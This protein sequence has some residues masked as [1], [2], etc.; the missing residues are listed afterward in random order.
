MLFDSD[1]AIERFN[2]SDNL[3]R[4]FNNEVSKNE[5]PFA[6]LMDLD[7]TKEFDRTEFLTEKLADGRRINTQSIEFTDAE[8]SLGAALAR[9]DTA[10]NVAKVIGCTKNPIK[11]WKMGRTSDNSAMNPA[12]VNETTRKLNNIRDVAMD[13]L[14]ASMGIIDDESLA[15]INAKDASII[16]ANMSKVVERTLPKDAEGG[17]K[18]QVIMYAPQQTNIESFQVVEI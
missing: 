10:N 2:S 16:A 1:T 7:K 15:E 18:V 3:L 5:S 11:N 13:K 8:R 14:L 9:I 4:K 6:V 17:P 12:L